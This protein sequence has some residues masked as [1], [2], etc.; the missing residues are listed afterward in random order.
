MKEQCKRRI[1]CICKRKFE[2]D[3]HHHFHIHHDEVAFKHWHTTLL[4]HVY[5]TV[6]STHSLSF[7]VHLSL[8][9]LTPHNF[10]VPCSVEPLKQAVADFLFLFPHLICKVVL[11]SICTRETERKGRIVHVVL[12]SRI[13]YKLA[14]IALYSHYPS[15][16]AAKVVETD[17]R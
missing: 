11:H 8:S 14:S 12:S 10:S 6:Y 1:Y 16:W 5:Q 3:T 4:C 17:E 2:V 7:T 13:D 9:L 15:K